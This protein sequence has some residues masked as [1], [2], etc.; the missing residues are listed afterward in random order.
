MGNTDI[1]SK[2][3]RSELMSKVRS[4][5][6]KPE[7]IIRSHLHNLGYRF[8][9]HIKDLPGCPDLTLKKYQTVIFIHG[10]FWHQHQNCKKA[11]I[12]KNNRGFWLNKLNN[13]VTRD[14]KQE[15]MLRELGWNVIAIWECDIYKDLE[16]VIIYI[17]S[18]LSKP[19]GP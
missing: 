17:T 9:I 14:K 18:Q 13:T 19:I 6:T 11:T 12:P 7:L 3:K 1:Y 15:I 5:N 8:R 4:K 10:C 2:V 16:S